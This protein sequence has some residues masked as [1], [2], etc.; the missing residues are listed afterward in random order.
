MQSLSTLYVPPIPTTAA[1]GT[2][3]LES[4]AAQ[5]TSIA[6]NFPMEVGANV[7]VPLIQRKRQLTRAQILKGISSLPEPALMAL[8]NMTW[9]R[10]VLEEI[11]ESRAAQAPSLFEPNGSIQFMDTSAA[12]SALME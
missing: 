12:P 9:P 1:A 2:V 7:E 8:A 4:K 5:A 11:D 10:H 6:E 3:V